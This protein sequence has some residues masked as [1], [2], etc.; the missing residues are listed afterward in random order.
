MFSYQIYMLYAKWHVL[1]SWFCFLSQCEACNFSFICHFDVS[2]KSAVYQPYVFTT[3]NGL[4]LHVAGGATHVHQCS[5]NLFQTHL[6]K[7]LSLS[8]RELMCEYCEENGI[9]KVYYTYPDV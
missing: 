1:N 4:F 2:C 8:E 6:Y 7:H 5:V 9:L 3:L